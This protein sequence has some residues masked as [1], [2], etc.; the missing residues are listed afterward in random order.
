MSYY[1]DETNEIKRMLQNYM[2]VRKLYSLV[3]KVSNYSFGD[4]TYYI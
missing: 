1:V 2:G 4:N 3:S